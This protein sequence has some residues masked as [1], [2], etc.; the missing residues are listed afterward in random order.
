MLTKII[1]A[2][3]ALA[4]AVLAAPMELE[5]RDL[6]TTTYT[7]TKTIGG[8]QYGYSAFT[9]YVTSTVNGQLTTYPSW[10]MVSSPISTAP[11]VTTTLVR[12]ATEGGVTQTAPTSSVLP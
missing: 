9:S 12:T 5:P 10:V 2:I 4:S 8:T 11:V 1:L 3:S 6:F 7:A